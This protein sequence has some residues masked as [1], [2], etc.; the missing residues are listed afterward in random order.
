MAIV[1]KKQLKATSPT[2]LKAKL[3]EIEVEFKRSLLVRDKN[4][5]KRKELRKLKA[6]I[7]NYLYIAASK[8]LKTK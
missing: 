8:V 4:T 2:E 5:A 7:L 3:Q 6:R 1:K